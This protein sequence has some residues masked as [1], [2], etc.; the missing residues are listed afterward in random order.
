MK[1]E[2]LNRVLIIIAIVIL[3]LITIVVF[4][5]MLVIEQWFIG[6]ITDQKISF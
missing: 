3:I 5:M 4:D 6:W 1:N 2:T